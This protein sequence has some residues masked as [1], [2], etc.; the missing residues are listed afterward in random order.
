MRPQLLGM[1]LLAPLLVLALVAP[2][3]AAQASPPPTMQ[4][5]VA[6]DP[7]I[8]RDPHMPAGQQH[9]GSTSVNLVTVV[10]TIPA[11]SICQGEITIDLSIS[12][13]PH[14]ATADLL[15]RTVRFNADVVGG[16]DGRQYKASTGLKI[17]TAADAPAFVEWVYELKASA[18]TNAP[19]CQ[20]PASR[21]EKF[22]IRNDFVPG[23]LVEPL[24]TENPAHNGTVSVRVTN[25]ANGPARVQTK[26]EMGHP[27]GFLGQPPIPELRLAAPKDSEG[28]EASGIIEI[29]YALSRGGTETFT[30]I[31]TLL[32][33]GSAVDA[34]T[35]TD[36]VGFVV[37]RGDAT[38]LDPAALPFPGLATF[39]AVLAAALWARRRDGP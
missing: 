28:G 18:S 38:S 15:P 23:L 24:V 30:G 33:D 16:L 13:S 29:P 25:L 17:S 21:S 34:S 22:S 5:N 9:P 12:H 31:F 27:Q 4:L 14:W 6:L 37:G 2:M 20:A 11:P 39:A 7:H 8:T 32:Y 19:G 10:V 3:G 1:P 36:S 35:A 26:L